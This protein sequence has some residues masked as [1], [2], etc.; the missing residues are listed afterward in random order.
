MGDS[1][2]ESHHRSKDHKKDHRKHK[3][4]ETYGKLV[5]SHTCRRHKHGKHHA[6]QDGDSESNTT[7]REKPSPGILVSPHTGSMYANATPVH[8]L[9]HRVDEPIETASTS[10]PL[11]A[12]YSATRDMYPPVI[13]QLMEIVVKVIVE[14]RSSQRTDD[15]F[16]GMIPRPASDTISS[17][18][19]ILCGTHPIHRA[20]NSARVRSPNP[21][22][23]IMA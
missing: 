3:H 4:D 21:L 2:R 10:T 13:D 15:T 20:V 14:H 7:Q 5:Q 22:P 19:R 8:Q 1:G 16:S 17:I 12:S 6:R 18:P 23:F 9:I 11:L